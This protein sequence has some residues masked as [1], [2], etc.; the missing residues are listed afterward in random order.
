[1]KAASG[2]WQ[3]ELS[4]REPALTRLTKLLGLH[5][6]FSGWQLRPAIAF[7]YGLTILLLGVTAALTWMF[8]PE[9]QTFVTVNKEATTTPSPTSA[10]PAG[11]PSP[12]QKPT[13]PSTPKSISRQTRELNGQPEQSAALVPEK[14]FIHTIG[15]QPTDSRLGEYLRDHLAEAG[16]LTIASE[17]QADAALKLSSNSDGSVTV[18]LVKPDGSVWWPQA[19]GKTGRRYTGAPEKIGA[20]ILIDLRVWIRQMQRK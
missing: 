1:M 19:G 6:V 13:P 8:W 3:V 10:I 4:Y 16:Q 7:S 9:R 12:N 14:I 18:W 20:E 5:S 2:K 17:Q 15:S 11:S